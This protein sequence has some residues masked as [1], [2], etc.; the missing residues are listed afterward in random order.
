MSPGKRYRVLHTTSYRYGAP[1]AL[2]R[3]LLHLTPRDLPTQ[4]LTIQCGCE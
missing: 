1:V 3:Q 2:S 4:R